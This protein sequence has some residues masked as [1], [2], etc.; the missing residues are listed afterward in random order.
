MRALIVYTELTDDDSVISHAV[1]R[2][3]SELNDEHVETVII[4]NFEDGMAYIRSNTSIDCLLYGRDMSDKQ[5]QTQAHQLITQL[6]RRQEDV[7]VFLLSDREEALTAFDRKMMEQVDEFAWILED[8]ADFI[9]GRVLAAIIRYRANLLP[10]LMKS[11]IKYS[12]VHEYSWAA[13]GH[14]GGVG[15]TKTPAGRIYHDFFGE[16]LFRTDIGI[17]RVAVGSLL[18]HTGAFGECE[19]NAARIFGADQSYSVVV[20]TSGS[21]RTIM[22]ACM[23][24]NDVVVIDRNCH[25]S[26]EQGLILTGAKPVYMTPSRN[27]Y[28]IIGPIYPQEMTPEAITEKIAK[29]PLTSDKI[30]KRPAYSV[31]TNCTYDG[32]CYHARKVQDLLDESLDRIHFDE[33]WYGY[34]RFNP[35]YRDHF[36]MRDDPRKDDEP[37]VFA[38]HSTHKLLN[39]LSQASFIHIRNGRN[40]IDF[41]RFNQA[42]HMHATT[43][44]LYAICASNDIAADMMDGNSGR[45]LTDEVIREAIDF[46]QSL[47]YLY[48]EFIN[49]DE[50]F[51][52]PW[53]QEMVKDPATGKRYAFEDAP[54]E[55]LMKEQSCWVM[56]PED[57]WHGFKD[58]P[59]NWAMLDPIKVSI[60][61][62]GMGDDGKLL[63]SGV[64]AALVTA[65]LNHYGIVPTRTTDFQIMFLFSMGI[66]KGK[67]G[68]L[69]NALLSFKRHYDNNTAL[70][71]VLPEVVEASPEIYGEMGLR[72]L[73]NKM[74]VYLQKNNPGGQLNQAYEQLPAVMMS[75]R[76]AYQEI[77]AN[78]VEAIPLDKLAGRIAANS[79]IPYPPGI[80]MLLSG[81]SFG[82]KNSPHI[83]YLHSL[84]AWDSEFPGFEHETEGTEIIDG[85]YYVMCVKE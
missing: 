60:L 63:D 82:D 23:T 45:S 27:R 36:A 25:K 85:Q 35:I 22:Q 43:S 28:G 30:G 4:R 8:S 3:A 55:L 68:T 62:P 66:T 50:W 31:V 79:I 71:K 19:R 6:H 18:D 56:N 33:A 38:T 69:V 7:P 16:N 15:F 32:V 39:A 83:G 51:F 59:E 44:P 65:W 52:K 57:K 67:W 81:E 40:A 24:D 72:D 37:T 84:Q 47:G 77:V 54:V 53:N 76:D 49:D 46:R 5:E 42:Y 61:S 26:I 1:A 14:Q 74:F 11:L 78:R 70:K 21:N 73:G 80:P 17:E 64:P 34:A 12:D 13:P 75:P 20:G 29:N 2:L 48:K 58:I 10:P 41:N 9:A